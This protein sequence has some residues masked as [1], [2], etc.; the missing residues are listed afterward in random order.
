MR[1]FL[2]AMLLLSSVPAYAE[3]EC[4]ISEGPN[5]I[6][7]KTGDIVVQA[8]Q[9]VEDAIALDGTITIKK[10][11]MVKSA[12]AFHGNVVVEDGAKVS[13]SALSI[14]GTVKAAN[15]S[16]VKNQIEIS[17]KGLRIRGTDGEDLDLNLVIGG[18][19]MGQRIADEALA[20]MKN[21]KISSKK[22]TIAP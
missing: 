5:D 15:G 22:S 13:M 7:K 17:E 18:K 4:K 14:G 6:V 12:I 1:T 3:D 20:K 9:Y 2:T 11:A 10:G 19:S 21:C 8:G 16:R